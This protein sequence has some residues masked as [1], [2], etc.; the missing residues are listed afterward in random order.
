MRENAE[1]FV[2]A[3]GNFALFSGNSV[4]WQVRLRG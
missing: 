1:A 3:G 2:A 4:C